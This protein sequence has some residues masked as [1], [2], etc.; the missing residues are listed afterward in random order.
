MIPI[1][2][3]LRNIVVGADL[4]AASSRTLTLAAEL[5]RGANA[6]LHL[7]HA[8]AQS[9]AYK[10]TAAGR[11]DDEFDDARRALDIIRSRLADEQVSI[12][13]AE[14]FASGRPE[15][16]LL[17]RAN[18]VSADLIVVGSTAREGHGHRLGSTA[19]RLVRAGEHAVLVVRGETPTSVRRV[20]ILTDFSEGAKAV[21]RQGVAW[22]PSLMSSA[23]TSP[24]DGALQVDFVHAGDERVL[25]MDATVEAWSRQRLDE[26]VGH[27][28]PHV[29]AGIGVRQRLLWGTHPVD[30]IE[31]AAVEHDWHLIVVGTHGKGTLTR[32]V[33]GSVAIGLCQGAPCPV[34][35]MPPR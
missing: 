34:L 9:E 10:P 32:W 6:N 30:T 31:S 27:L 13:S 16:R 17:E 11:H 4:Q 22:L 18:D 3:T 7:V 12:A 29:P 21:A 25:A 19:D 14:C 20:A 35:V 28:K 24:G 8:A 5:A 33:V 2:N 26:E 23:H 1:L 15:D